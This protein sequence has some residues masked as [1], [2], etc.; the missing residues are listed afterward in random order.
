[1]PV[2]VGPIVKERG[3]MPFLIIA[4]DRGEYRITAAG[5]YVPESVEEVNLSDL[6]PAEQRAVRRVLGIEYEPDSDEVL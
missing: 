1:M 5:L 2:V 6:S 4:S 3:P